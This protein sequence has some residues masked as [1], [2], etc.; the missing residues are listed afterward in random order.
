[1]SVSAVSSN[2]Q[3]YQPVLQQQSFRQDLQSLTTAVQSG[4]LASAQK[5]YATLVSDNP[6]LASS[7]GNGSGSP[8]QQAISAIGQ[9]LQNS[10]I[11]GAQNALSTLQQ[12]MKAHHG[13]HHHHGDATQNAAATATP[14]SSPLSASSSSIDFLA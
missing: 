13:H 4:D 6:Q 7:S 3:I 8:F 14:A 1:M 5:A 2:P 12:N 11:G 9:S 10:D